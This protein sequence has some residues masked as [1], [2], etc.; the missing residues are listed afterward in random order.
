M[1]SKTAIL[2]DLDGTLVDTLTDLATATNN[3]LKK[4][5]LPIHPTEAFRQFVGNGAMMQIKRALGDHDASSLTETIYREY[6]EEYQARCLETVHPY[7][8]IVEML[9]TLQTLGATVGIVT[10]KPDPQ[11]KAIAAHLFPNYPFC[12]VCGVTD[13]TPKKP[14]PTVALQVLNKCG[15]AVER[16][17]FVGDSDV[18]V[19]TAKNIGCIGIGVSWGFR[20]PQELLDANT[21]FLANTPQE[22]V[23][24]LCETF[25]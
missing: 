10:N 12:A 11:A 24:I 17:A 19:H 25:K 16:A 7:E 18:D 22:V 6:L 2:F 13:E 4:H 23:D 14:D 5:E 20:G 15:I 9:N 21:Q 1:L 8:G 3:V